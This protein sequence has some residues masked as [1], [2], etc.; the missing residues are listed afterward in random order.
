MKKC[1]RGR[2]LRRLALACTLAVAATAHAQGREFDVAAGDLKAA[3]DAYIAQAGVQLFYKVDDIKGL[4]TKG[5]KG[6]L[7]PE[8]ALAR[9]L[10]GTRLKVRRDESGAMVLFVAPPE[11]PKPRADVSTLDSVM[12]SAARR[13]EPVREVPLKVDVLQ[14]E[15]LERGGARELGD[16][17]ADQPGVT[18]THG[19]AFAGALSIRGL[20][21]ASVGAA[22]VGVYVDDVATGSSAPYGLGAITPL[23]MGLLDLHHIEIL[24]GPQG[25]LYGAGAMGGLIKYVTNE[26]DT[27]EFSGSARLAL[28]STQYGG[29]GHT[30]NGVVNVPLKA[31]V[32]ALRFAAYSTRF[33]GYDDTIGRAAE[34]NVNR[35][36]TTG[37]RVSALLTPS[38]NLSMRLTLTTQEAERVGN[39]YEDL[40]LVT[41][42]S[43]LGERR[44]R[45]D[46]REPS[47]VR[48]QLLG[49]DIEYN[50]GWARL[51][52]ITSVQDVRL[53]GLA[54]AS[55]SILPVLIRAGVPATS[56]WGDSRGKQHRVSQEFRLTSRASRDIEWLAGL[57][58]NRERSSVA[59]GLDYSTA[60]GPGTLNLY[61]TS[62]PATYRDLAVYG[63]VTW[64]ATPALALTGGVRVGRMEQ[65]FTNTSAGLLAGGTSSNGGESKETATT[66]LATA[67]YK[68]DPQSS[69]YARIASGYRPGGPNGLL[70]TT[71]PTIKPMFKSDS[72][73]SYEAGYKAALLD[74]T[75]TVEAAVYDI[76]WSDIQQTVSDGGIFGFFTN[77]GK[78]RIRGG[79]LGLSWLP[80]AGWRF[81]GSLSLIDAKLRT[82]AQGLG[83]HAGDKLP[84]TARVSASLSATRNFELDGRPA[85][86]GVNARHVGERNAGFTGSATLPAYTLPAYTVYGLQA[87]V[88]FERFKLSAYLRNL[89]NSRGLAAVAIA[90]A[91][92]GKAVVVEPRTLGLAVNV[93]F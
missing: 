58:I 88:D 34:K 66:W 30:V 70:P 59:G 21:T 82:D 50:M 61:E 33:G 46:A 3:L 60:S 64:H 10:E 79:E 74:R 80:S 71:S 35:G 68:L 32:A 78:A 24:R 14:T 41:G 57:Y 19:G 47:S 73:W 69:V 17:V 45:L 93:P 90:S 52:A 92:A 1:V 53:H 5:L 40:N 51:N 23:D 55:S 12:V 15:A 63:D 83:G 29:M 42:Q 89:T 2:T 65:R 49:M 85:Y 8:Q 38:R 26:P 16:Y 81:D 44:R 31:D 28:S 4:S 22:S 75:L 54:D 6:H 9:L 62:K 86:F 27:G 36:T 72:L 37:A 48:T 20:A 87:G 67:G 43:P 91:T 18:L 76:E 11:D 39:D 56:V 25:T 77:A 84:N 7:P 13:R